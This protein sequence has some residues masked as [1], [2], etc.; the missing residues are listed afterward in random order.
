MSCVSSHSR[1]WRTCAQVTGFGPVGEGLAL[2]PSGVPPE[3]VGRGRGRYSV[4]HGPPGVPFCPKPIIGRS[5]CRLL[6]CSRS[7]YRRSGLG[8]LPIMGHWRN[9]GGGVL[10]AGLERQPWM[11]G[12]GPRW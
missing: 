2:K 7:H 9:L 11:V 3:R 1:Y 4:G 12:G 5:F 10:D 8:G 6:T